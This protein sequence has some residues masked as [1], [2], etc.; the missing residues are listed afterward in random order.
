MKSDIGIVMTEF[1]P[2]ATAII[3]LIT[4]FVENFETRISA[5]EGKVPRVPVDPPV[6]ATVDTRDAEICE[7]RTSLANA[8][9]ALREADA[10]KKRAW[11]EAGRANKEA[12]ALRAVL[13]K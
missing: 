12:A 11:D 3:K 5:L 6:G 13:R 2:Q 9:A 4:R 10:E 1:I 7:L 8:Q